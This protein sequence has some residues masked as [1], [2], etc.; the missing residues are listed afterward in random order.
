M[1]ILRAVL[2][3]LGLLLMTVSLFPL[4]PRAERFDAAWFFRAGLLLAI[5]SHGFPEGV[6]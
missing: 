4:P 6:L 1:S 5:G 2:F 3:L